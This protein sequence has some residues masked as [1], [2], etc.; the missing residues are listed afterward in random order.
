MKNGAKY[1][2][3]AAKKGAILEEENKLRLSHS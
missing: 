3:G 1:G 2:N